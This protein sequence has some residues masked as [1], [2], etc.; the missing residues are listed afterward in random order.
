MC[1][2][3]CDA[4]YCAIVHEPQSGDTGFKKCLNV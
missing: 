3:V 2:T 4:N 1:D